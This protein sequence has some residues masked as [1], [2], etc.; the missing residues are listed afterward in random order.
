MR[1]YLDGIVAW[2]R[3]RAARESRDLSELAARAEHASLADPPRAFRAAIATRPGVGV[4][5]EIKRRSPSAGVIAGDV[6]AAEVA[7]EYEAGGACCLSVLTDSP[8]FGGRPDDLVRARAAS[9]LPVLRKDFT[10]CE[11]DVHDARL[12]GADAVLLIAAVLDDDELRRLHD[13]ATGLSMAALVEVHDEAELER[14]LSCGASLIGVNQ[15]DLRS[16]E[17][18]PNRA[19]RVAKRVPPGVVKVAESGMRDRKDVARMEDAGYDGVLVGEALMAS[20]DRA[21]AV[22]ELSGGKA[23]LGDAAPLRGAP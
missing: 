16:F 13:L 14:A 18:D 4:V 21:G 11:A 2:H 23:R 7:A 1:T 6:V 9:S 12:M 15:R 19:E 5:A 3:A 10:V 17:V 20:G 22:R 8:H